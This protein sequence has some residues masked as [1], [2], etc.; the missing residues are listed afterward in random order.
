M[1]DIRPIER[2][3]DHGQTNG[4]I[5]LD[6]YYID[7]KLISP[8]VMLQVVMAVYGGLCGRRYK[9]Q[10]YPLAHIIHI[11]V[12]QALLISPGKMSAQIP[13]LQIQIIC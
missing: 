2:T 9:G 10:L 11:M 4:H 3:L 7:V 13:M 12:I 5:E 6:N 1:T 8:D